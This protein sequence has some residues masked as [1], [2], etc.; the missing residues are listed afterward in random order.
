MPKRSSGVF[1]NK[2]NLKFNLEIVLIM[3]LIIIAIIFVSYM[4]AAFSRYELFDGW[5]EKDKIEHD[6]K[7]NTPYIHF[8]GSMVSSF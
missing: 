3:A 2:L 1:N 8:L 7:K 5:T 4:S 6:K